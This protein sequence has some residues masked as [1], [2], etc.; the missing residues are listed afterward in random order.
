MIRQIL[1]VSCMVLALC[2]SGC[3]DGDTSDTSVKTM[4]EYRSEAAKEV[5][6]A[7]AE[8]ALDALEKEIDADK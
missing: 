2:L 1:V 8:D 5:T 3:T 4:D 6:D 7:N